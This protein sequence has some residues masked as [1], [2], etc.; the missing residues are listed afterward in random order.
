MINLF[1]INKQSINHVW[2][3]F[4]LRGILA[5]LFAI[6]LVVWPVGA[7]VTLAWVWGIFIFV[8]GVF[9][10]LGAWRTK[11]PTSRPWVYILWGVI[12]VLAGLVAICYPGLTAIAFVTIIGCWSILSGVLL[13]IANLATRHIPGSF[14][15]AM[16]FGIIAV[17]FGCMLL[18]RPIE[19]VV[20]M[21]WL[22]A[23][24]AIMAGTFFMGIGMKLR[25]GQ[26]PAE[27][28]L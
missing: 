14:L 4:I 11:S 18:A 2:W 20:A 24:Y 6:T 22:T 21:A 12:S 10:L 27:S 23:F 13:V 17:L 19:A 26:P 15:S 16:L 5:F 25:T 8:D 9:C 1:F 3:W 28:D 7:I